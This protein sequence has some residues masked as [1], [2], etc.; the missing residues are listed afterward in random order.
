VQ[1]RELRRGDVLESGVVSIQVLH[2]WSGFYTLRGREDTAMNNSSLV[3]RIAGKKRSFLLAGDVEGEAVEDMR[4]LGGRLESDVLKIPHHGKD[5]EP[6][7]E[8][9]EVVTPQ[10]AVA[11]AGRLRAESRKHLEGT[12][13]L[14][15]GAEGAIR[16]E[17]RGEKLRVK[18]YGEYILRET[19]DFREE[20]RNFR[21]LFTVW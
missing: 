14:V 18:P 13:V 2:P 5:P 4:H 10:V 16:I 9:T 3:L 17:E 21:R 7:R 15:T 20:L 1:R 12:R 8:L 11:S 6:L 19:A